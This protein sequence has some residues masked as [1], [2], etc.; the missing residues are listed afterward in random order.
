MIPGR[1]EHGANEHTDECEIGTVGS[2]DLQHDGLIDDVLLHAGHFVSEHD[3]IFLNFCEVGEF[4]ALDFLEDGVG[5][6]A[7]SLGDVLQPQL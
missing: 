7:S 2:K 5:C 4:G 3:D 6:R 1:S